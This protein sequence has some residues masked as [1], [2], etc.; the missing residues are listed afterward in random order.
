MGII[1][2]LAINNFDKLKDKSKNLS[3]SNLKEYLTSFPHQRDVEIICIDKCLN[4]SIFV[5]ANKTKDIGRFLNS[6]VKRYRYDFYDGYVKIENN[7][8]FNEEDI[9]EEVCFSYKLNQD[10]IGEQV[11]IKYNDKFYNFSSYFTDVEIYNSLDEATD[12]K[13]KLIEEVIR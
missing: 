7:V 2:T 6:D 4:C 9:E 8:F 10:D 12:A 1:Y 13:E 11:L 5:D 3:L